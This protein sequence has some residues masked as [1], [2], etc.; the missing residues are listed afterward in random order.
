MLSLSD[1]IQILPAILIA[2]T[3]HEAAHGYVAYKLGDNTA[4]DA[5]RL[6]INPI[7][8]IDPLGLIAL[9]V[10]RFGWAKPVPVDPRNF[11]HP[12]R[13]MAL[14][15]LA[16]PV[17]NLLL[18]FI[19][20]LICA[21]ILISPSYNRFLSA[22]SVFLIFLA[23]INVGLA[24]FNLIPIPPLDGSRLLTLLL[25]QK[26]VFYLYKYERYIMLA[27]IA[28][29]MFGVLSGPLSIARQYVISWMWGAVRWIVM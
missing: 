18:G 7:K 22:F 15:A 4:K 11:K 26:A 1:I 2:L 3:F 12:R 25:P 14:T 5:G 19:S 23:Q 21:I 20:I 13:G 16:G 6:T 29:L 28:L 17:T 8:H 27:V 10:F 9:L 24:I